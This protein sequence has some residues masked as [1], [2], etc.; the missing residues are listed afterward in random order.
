MHHCTLWVEGG[1]A[2]NIGCWQ[3]VCHI[4]PFCA[5][6]QVLGHF[7]DRFIMEMDANAIVF[8]LQ[9]QGIIAGGYRMEITKTPDRI[10]QNMILH[11]HLK[12]V[13]T[14]EA[15]MTVCDMII[16]VPGYPKMRA[17]G[18]D[19]KSM[20]ESKCCVSRVHTGGVQV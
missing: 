15:L 6:E 14:K 16:A 9:H 12:R 3:D 11:E 10:Q 8:V 18:K 7:R 19:M 1:P 4:S 17:L 5:A 2:M 20:L 13:C